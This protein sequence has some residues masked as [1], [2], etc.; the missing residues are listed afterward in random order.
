[1]AEG[2]TIIECSRVV[3][4]TGIR[5]P[6]DAI[7]LINGMLFKPLTPVTYLGGSETILLAAKVEVGGREDI[8]YK[9][10]MEFEPAPIDV[11]RI[12]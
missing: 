6:S 11:Y 8:L 2:F 1:M 10:I 4:D 12:R 7:E 3:F 5:D 9:L